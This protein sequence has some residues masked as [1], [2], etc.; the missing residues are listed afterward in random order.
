MATAMAG[1][2]VVCIFEREE[3]ILGA[4]AAARERGLA[5]DDVYAPYA[6]HGLDDAMGLPPSRLPWVCFLLGLVG[7]TS[8]FAFQ[9][10]ANTTSWAIN[11]GGRPWNSW[12]AFVPV[13][14]EVTVLFAGVG[15]VLALCVVAGLQPWRRPDVPD[16]R[17]TDDRFALVL[18]A[19]SAKLDRAGIE[20]LMARFRPASIEERPGRG[21]SRGGDT[22]PGEAL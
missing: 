13:T 8:M 16:P 21:I 6:V 19:D 1:K 7:G 5:I 20:A 3:D 4:T 2:V 22:Q 17:V 11:V 14:F 9:Y 15:T 18:T 10:W 12:P